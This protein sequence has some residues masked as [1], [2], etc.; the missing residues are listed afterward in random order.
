MLRQLTVKNYALVESLD[1]AFTPGMTVITGESGAGKSIILGALGLVLGD[2]AQ[3]DHVRP[4]SEKADISA[5][6]DIG[7]MPLATAFL[8]EYELEDED[9]SERCLIR[10]TVT[11]DGRSRAFVNGTPVTLQAL[12]TL[13]EDLVDIHGQHDHHRL[14]AREVQLALLDDFAG[15][16]KQAAAVRTDF[17][18][19]KAAVA[20]QAALTAEVAA[21]EDRAALLEYQVTELMEANLAEGEFPMLAAEHKRL[22][23]AEVI[24]RQVAQTLD[25]AEETPLHGMARD[26]N[27]ID[28]DQAHLLAARDIMAS[29]LTNLEEA[30]TELRAY[31][32]A[33]VADPGRLADL[34]ARMTVLYDLGRKHQVPP[35]NL[36][37]HADGL[38]RELDSLSTDRDA[39][40]ALD[41]QIATLH[42]AY[43][44]SADKLSKARRKAAKTFAASVTKRLR[45]LGIKD[46]KLDLQFEAAET[47]RGLERVDFLITTNPK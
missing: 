43:G 15:L 11:A 31:S 7:Q 9:A 2:R 40:T 32:D 25:Y 3:A 20:D 5:E 46:G 14:S 27:Q 30:A 35:E 1:I 38:K 13:T 34:D 42:A 24:Q 26:L 18:S 45:E 37:E 22:S 33:F 29:A 36:F 39:L 23:H 8:S 4:G 10:R 21:K 44:K 6:F 17:L 41:E 16:N 19:W 12:R 28:D 47:E